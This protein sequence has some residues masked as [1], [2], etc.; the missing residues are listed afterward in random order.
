[1]ILSYFLVVQLDS[2]GYSAHRYDTGRSTI[3]GETITTP[4]KRG[5]KLYLAAEAEIRASTLRLQTRGE[6]GIEPAPVGTA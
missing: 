4:A 3:D 5:A 1:M 2:A 6:W